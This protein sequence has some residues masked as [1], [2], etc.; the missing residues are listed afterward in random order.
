MIGHDYQTPLAEVA[1]TLHAEVGAT[2]FRRVGIDLRAK[3]MQNLIIDLEDNGGGYLQAAHQLA[4]HFLEKGDM[5]VYTDAPKMGRSDFRVERA[6]DFRKGRL[7]IMA[8]HRAVGEGERSLNKT[9]AEGA[10]PYDE[11]AV[12]VLHGP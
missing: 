12:V 5:V 8:Y 9:F 7:V 6:G 3:G 11:A 2:H 10:A 4:S 1:G